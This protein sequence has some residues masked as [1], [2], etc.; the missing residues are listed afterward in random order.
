MD[1]LI[2]DLKTVEGSFIQMARHVRDVDPEM[3]MRY[4]KISEIC[5]KAREQ[6][7]PVP[8]ETE[9]DA[10]ATWW[11]VCG[12]CHTAIDKKDRYCRACGRQV[13]WK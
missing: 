2:R 9:G 11:Y 12:E 3:S 13:K 6:L 1:D 10:K 8:A 4:F 7:T 5:R